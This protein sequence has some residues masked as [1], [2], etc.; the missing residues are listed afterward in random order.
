MTEAK[1]IILYSVIHNE[2]KHKIYVKRIINDRNSKWNYTVVMFLY[3][4]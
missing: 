4:T 1:I 3:F 2:H